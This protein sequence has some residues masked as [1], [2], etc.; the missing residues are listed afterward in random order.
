MGKTMGRPAPTSRATLGDDLCVGEKFQSNLAIAGSLRNSLRA[1][2]VLL[3]LRGRATE[4]E[5]AVRR[6]I[7]NQTPN[8]HNAYHGSQKSGA[9]VGSQKG[10]SPDH[11]LRSLNLCSVVKE[12]KFLKHLG[13]WLRSSHPLKSA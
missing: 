9:K 3:H 13:G 12:V 4:W 8:S 10:N 7:S 2:V 1:S 5:F 11:H 6:R